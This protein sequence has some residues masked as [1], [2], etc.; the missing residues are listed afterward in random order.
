MFTVED[1]L[2]VSKESFDHIVICYNPTGGRLYDGDLKS[3][4]KHILKYWIG[5]L[6]SNDSETLYVEVHEKKTYWDNL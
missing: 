2:K 4:P 6:S 1:L 5:Y 3:I